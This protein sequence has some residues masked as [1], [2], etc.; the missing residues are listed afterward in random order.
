MENKIGTSTEASAKAENKTSIYF[1][2]AIGE[3]VYSSDRNKILVTIKNETR[4][5]AFRYDIFCT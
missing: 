4:T 1:K 2:Y 3:I 5:R